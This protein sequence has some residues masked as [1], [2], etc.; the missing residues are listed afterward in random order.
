[1][2]HAPKCGSPCHFATA[3]LQRR[4]D[5]GVGMDHRMHFVAGP[6]QRIAVVE[7]RLFEPAKPSTEHDVGNAQGRCGDR[8]AA[9]VRLH[10][11]RRPR[12]QN[13]GAAGQCALERV[14]S[15]H[16]ETRLSAIPIACCRPPRRRAAPASRAAAVVPRS[17]PATGGAS[18][19]RGIWCARSAPGPCSTPCSTTRR[20]VRRSRPPAGPSSRP[21]DRASR[22]AVREQ[23]DGDPS[24]LRARWW[25]AVLR[26]TGASRPRADEGRGPRSPAPSARRPT[27]RRPTDRRQCA[28]S[29]WTAG[30]SATGAAA[31][32]APGRARNRATIGRHRRR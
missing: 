19:G 11:G 26:T 25:A 13:G 23:A 14:E 24:R 29:P 27:R 18:P 17:R 1:M 7:K 4:A 10:P 21:R 5:R 12:R 9:S 20:A 28:G 32:P 3:R 6:A 8:H 15:Q 30:D 22:R 31:R 2:S 16:R